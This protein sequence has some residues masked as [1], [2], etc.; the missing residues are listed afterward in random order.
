MKS[1]REWFTLLTDK[2]QA[3]FKRNCD[4]FDTYMKG[5]SHDFNQFVASA[6]SFTHSPEGF[7]YW[8]MIQPKYTGNK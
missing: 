5:Y 8:N 6:F 3:E 7:N 1:N 4:D 2:E